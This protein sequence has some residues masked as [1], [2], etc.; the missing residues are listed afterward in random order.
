MATKKKESKSMEGLA[1]GI[2]LSLAKS[3]N[4]YIKNLINGRYFLARLNMIAEQLN[5]GNIKESIDGCLKSADLMRQEYGLMKMQAIN[6]MREA[7]FAKV[8][9]MSKTYKLTGKDIEAIESDYYD[10]KVI[11][12]EYDESYKKG[13]EA[14]FVDTP[15]N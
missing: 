9:L 15:K 7:H 12:E 3:K 13:K 10:G 8:E 4:D 14:K 2:K 1:Y 6:S 11:R 5:S